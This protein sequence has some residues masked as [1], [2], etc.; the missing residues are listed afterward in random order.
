MGLGQIENQTSTSLAL[1]T[2]NVLAHTPGLSIAIAKAVTLSILCGSRIQ[3]KSPEQSVH[4]SPT[5]TTADSYVP[6]KG[7]GFLR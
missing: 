4:Q 1:N 6:V 2:H 7:M 5:G 3:A